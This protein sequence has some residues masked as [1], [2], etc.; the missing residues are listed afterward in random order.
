MATSMSSAGKLL[1]ALLCAVSF[2]GLSLGANAADLP[3]NKPAPPPAAPV[4]APAPQLGFFVKLGLL[5]AI[6]SSSSKIYAASV[7]GG[8][9]PLIVGVNAKVQNVFTLGFEAGYFVTQNISLD[10]SGAIP[11]FA[12]VKTSGNF[13]PPLPI[14][15]GT[16]LATIMPGFIP[17]TALYHFQFGAFQPYIGGGLAPVFSFKP[18]D[19][20]STGVVVDPALGIVLQGGFDYMIDNHWGFTFD[21]K[22][23]FARTI[24]KA[25]GDNLAVIGLP[26]GIVPLAGELKTN[27]Q[28]WV[29][30]TGVTYR[31]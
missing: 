11:R 14:P 6:N 26:G 22:K 7:P 4:V 16:T 30:S 1:G 25:T 15:S 20:L 27:F 3:T 17:I 9:T 29:M 19:G 21:V 10:I 12:T 23:L 5:Y 18:K 13:P 28:P 31:F 2:L 8:P 24:T